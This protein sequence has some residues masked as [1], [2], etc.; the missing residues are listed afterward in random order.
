MKTDRII[1]YL[2][3]ISTAIICSYLFLTYQVVPV[4]RDAGYYIPVAKAVMNGSTPTVEVDTMYTPFLYYAY[5]I[6]MSMFGTDI[7]TLFLLLYLVNVLNGILFYAIVRRFID[8]NIV[9]FVLAVS[10]YFTTMI[11]QGYTIVLEPFQVAFILLA[12]IFYLFGIKP[13]LKFPLVGLSL[14]VSIMFKQY[15]VLVMTGFLLSIVIDFLRTKRSVTSYKEMFF[16]L[17]S[18]IIACTIPFCLFVVFTDAEMKTALN[19]FGFLGSRAVSYSIAESITPGER[20]LNVIIK[21][22][23]LNWLFIPPLLYVFSLIFKK[24]L[25]ISIDSK[26]EVMPIFLFSAFPIFIRQFGHYFLP[27]APWS[28]IIAAILLNTLIRESFVHEK[29]GSYL[30]RVVSLCIFLLFPLFVLI[31][32]SFYD[33]SKSHQAIFVASFILSVMLVLSIW[34]F[35]CKLSMNPKAYILI[36]LITLGA[37]SMFLAVKMPFSELRE[38]KER[39]LLE[40]HQVSMVLRKGSEVFVVDYPE[41]YVLCNYSN[42]ANFY[43]FIN[44]RNID[45]RMNSIDFDKISHVIVKKQNP[46]TSSGFFEDKGFRR[47]QDISG[48]DLSFFTRSA[49]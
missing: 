33:I 16:A 23:H 34:M 13:A 44:P 29:H 43:G 36:I 12:F 40:A 7:V 15:S 22:M 10:Y 8:S 18:V 42:P 35:V 9:C 6:W 38:V 47:G 20:L 19:S 46:V 4:N 37:E 41:L 24:G 30:L 5:S 48:T 14:G 3:I 17:F 31:S 26:T 1:L 21:V 45:K 32:P 28:Y 11:C 49:H 2:L 39:Q 25:S 27:I